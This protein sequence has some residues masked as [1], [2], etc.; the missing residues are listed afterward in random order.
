MYIN[1]Q[2]VHNIKWRFN[3]NHFTLIYF[4]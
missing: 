3:D 4:R 2:L 1:Y